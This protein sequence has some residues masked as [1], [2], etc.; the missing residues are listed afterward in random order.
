MNRLISFLLLSVACDGGAPIISPLLLSVDKATLEANGI[1]RATITATVPEGADALVVSF[2]ATGGLLSS[3]AQA[4]PS[5]VATVTLLADREDALLGRA[6]KPVTVRATITRAADDV[7]TATVDLVF[8]TPT[9]GAPALS[10]AADPPAGLADGIT[11]VT[12]TVTGRR[13]A[14]GTSLLLT[15]TAGTLSSGAVI[16]DDAGIATATLLAPSSPADAHVLEREPAGAEGTT[17]VSFVADGDA[18]FDLT[19]TFAQMAPARVRLRAGTLTPNPQCITAPAFVKVDIVQT[20]DAIDAVYTTCFVTLAPVTSIVGEVT[21]TAPPAFVGSIPAVHADF[22]LASLALGAAWAPPESIVVSGAELDSP[23]E[24]LPT[25]ADDPRVRDT[26]GDGRPGVTVVN[27]LGGEQNITFRNT[28]RTRG[29][30][31]SSNRILGATVGDM[32]ALPESSVLGAGDAFLPDFESVPSVF[33]MV[34]VD[35][36]NGAPDMDTNGDGSIACNEIV[37]AAAFLF[38]LE[39]PATPLDCAGVP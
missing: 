6:E 10:I 24:E 26:D 23:L 2:S 21:N 11:T 29:F 31:M 7:Q 35:G 20:E 8:V 5:G 17:T 12:L 15:T 30:L 9:T 1:D 16:L 38:S 28:G 33:E 32:S 3:S 39:A 37:D 36:K 4:P 14:P 27:S 34:R 13:I 18:Q 25:N 19:G 22:S